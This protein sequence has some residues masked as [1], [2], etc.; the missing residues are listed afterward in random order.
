MAVKCPARAWCA[1]VM[2][3]SPN[4]SFRVPDNESCPKM[5]GS[6]DGGGREGLAGPWGTHLARRASCRSLGQTHWSFPL[7]KMVSAMAWSAQPGQGVTSEVRRGKDKERVI[8]WGGDGAPSA[9]TSG[10]SPCQATCGRI[11]HRIPSPAK[12]RSLKAPL[13]PNSGRDN[14]VAHGAK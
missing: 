4:F 1:S 14:Y 7:P 6:R 13:S 3:L 12:Y 5:E 9:G 2:H 8:S 10:A 11:A